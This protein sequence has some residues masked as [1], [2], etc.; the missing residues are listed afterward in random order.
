MTREEAVEIIKSID[1]AYRAFSK[2][3]YNALEMAIKALERE[4]KLEGVIDTLQ[5]WIATADDEYDRE[6]RGRVCGLKEAL[7]L[8][9]KVGGQ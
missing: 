3:E 7:H 1:K 6:E 5:V 8:I 9:K 4:S 2:E